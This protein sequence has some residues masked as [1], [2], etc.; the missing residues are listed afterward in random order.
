MKAFYFKKFC[1]SMKEKKIRP[2]WIRIQQ[3]P[4]SESEFNESG[5][6]TLLR[7]KRNKDQILVAASFFVCHHGT[8]STF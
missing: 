8:H 2:D 6:E 5:S 7:T 3:L 1:G 4:G